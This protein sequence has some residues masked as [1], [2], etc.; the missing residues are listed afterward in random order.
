MNGKR[1]RAFYVN[2]TAWN[3][4]GDVQPHIEVGREKY[5]T[6]FDD[7]LAYELAAARR[8]GQVEAWEEA[9]ASAYLHEDPHS[10]SIKHEPNPYRTGVDQ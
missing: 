4:G 3:F 6:E 10:I 1:I 5:A 7:W 9:V 2:A 8:E